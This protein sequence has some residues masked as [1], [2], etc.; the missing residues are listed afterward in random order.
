VAASRV[1]ERHR[2]L[3][4]PPWNRIDQLDAFP[5]KAFELRRE[6]LDFQA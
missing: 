6:I 1:N 2:S 3:G 4:T 5:G